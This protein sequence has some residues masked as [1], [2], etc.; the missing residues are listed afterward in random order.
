MRAVDA[1]QIRLH[2]RTAAN[3]HLEPTGWSILIAV[4]KDQGSNRRDG[5]RQSDGARARLAAAAASAKDASERHVSIAVSRRAVERN[6]RVAATVLAGGLAYRLFLWLLPF[7]LIVGGALGLMN[8]DN[9]EQ[10]VSKGGLPAAI[11]N[12]IGD[13]SRSTHS[14]SWW[15]LL[16]GVSALIWTGYSGAKAVQLVYSLIWDQAPPRTKPLKGSLA[17]TGTACAVWAA[18]GVTWW[19]RDATWHGPVIAA[20]TV[21]P[22]AALWLGVSLR[23]PHRDAPWRSLIPGALLVGIGF[24]VLHELIVAFLVPKL[25]KAQALYGVLG[26]ATTLIFFIYLLAML[27]VLAAVL[28]SSL[29]EELRGGRTISAPS[30]SEQPRGE[31]A[32]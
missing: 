1:G 11:S 28:N 16:V 30:G 17:F 29:Y 18:I 7:G 25:Q 3:G 8:A 19:V 13:A 27:V 21:A 26:A 14:D 23:L 32:R 31:P 12:A 20:L 24:P 5:T 15:L 2:A 6:Q 10:A 9:T 4:D 22:I